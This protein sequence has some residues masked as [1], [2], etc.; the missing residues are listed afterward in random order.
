[1]KGVENTKIDIMN[2][3][4]WNIPEYEPLEYNDERSEPYIY[5][6]LYWV[7]SD[8][9]LAQINKLKKQTEESSG[10]PC[11]SK[12][13]KPHDM[14]RKAIVIITFVAFENRLKESDEGHFSSIFKLKFIEQYHPFS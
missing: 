9:L 13:V 14:S 4:L 2:M 8:V 1:M 10:L 5:C 11:R 7:I 6:K 12:M 3:N